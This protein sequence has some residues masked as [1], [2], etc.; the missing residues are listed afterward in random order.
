MRKI[1]SFY[2]MLGMLFLLSVALNAYTDPARNQYSFATIAGQANMAEVEMANT[3]LAKS[4]NA[5][6]KQ[7]AQM[8]VDDHTKANDE[9][10][11]LAIQKHYDFPVALSS[12]QQAMAD[13][14]SGL[15]ASA[16]D[17][18]FVN[19]MISDHEK[20]ISLFNSEAKSGKDPEMKAW[21]TATLPTLKAHLQAAEA[22]RAKVK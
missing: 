16:F 13:H 11:T 22:L 4:Q 18:E 14:L 20:A 12:T 6:V 17:K 19:I 5:D 8:M 9:L 21:A 2:A 15:A 7:F 1:F 10:K 3:A